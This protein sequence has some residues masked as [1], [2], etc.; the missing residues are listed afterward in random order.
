MI[1][2]KLSNAHLYYGISKRIEKALKWLGSTDLDA[3]SPG[4]HEIEGDNIYARVSTAETKPVEQ[5][6]LETHYKYIDIQYV[7][8][9]KEYMG[10]LPAEFLGKVVKNDIENDVC[11]FEGTPD[12]VTT[13]AGYFMLVFPHDAHAPRI[14]KGS[15]MKTHKVVVKIKWPE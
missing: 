6:Q 2:D 1:F 3:L 9:G 4:S 14:A 7:H 12:L 13:A 8:K 15:P 11:F 10:T 5:C